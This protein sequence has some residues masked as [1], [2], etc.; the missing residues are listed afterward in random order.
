MVVNC[1]QRNVEFIHPL[2]CRVELWSCVKSSKTTQL[3]AY[4]YAS[5]EENKTTNTRQETRK[6]T[7]KT[8]YLPFPSHPVSITN[9]TTN[10]KTDLPEQTHDISISFVAPSGTG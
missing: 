8:K 10:L 7:T 9:E 1:M 5:A 2:N 3:A 4:A 6:K